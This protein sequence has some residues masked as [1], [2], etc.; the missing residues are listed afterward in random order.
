MRQLIEFHERFVKTDMLH[1]YVE[2]IPPEQDTPARRLPMKLKISDVLEVDVDEQSVDMDDLVV[3]LQ[4]HNCRIGRCM[5][6]IHNMQCCRF[7]YPKDRADS[8]TV[9]YSRGKIKGQ[10]IER[11][12]DQRISTHNPD[13][14]RLWRANGDFS[15][16]HDPIRVERYVT[17]YASKGETK[18]GVFKTAYAEVFNGAIDGETDTLLALRQVT[19]KV[20]GNRDVSMSEAL[21]TLQD[22]PLHDSN[23]TV[24]RCSLE[25]TLEIGTDDMGDYEFCESVAALYANRREIPRCD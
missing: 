5:K 10:A 14:L 12:N 8:T 19:T 11:R 20:L 25:A 6:L 13:I 22:L 16:T 9:K 3:C 18:S 24:L 21:H 2:Y 15:I 23:V 4:R 1:P 17:K 7:K